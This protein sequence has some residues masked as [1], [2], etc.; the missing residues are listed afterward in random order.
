MQLNG[1]DDQLLVKNGVVMVNKVNKNG[2]ENMTPN[3]IQVPEGASD[4]DDGLTNTEEAKHEMWKLGVGA[5][6]QREQQ[7]T[8]P[9]SQVTENEICEWF[10]GSDQTCALVVRLRPM[11]V[12]EHDIQL[13]KDVAESAM[14]RCDVF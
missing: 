11:A 3:I 2:K 14:L 7:E 5:Q 1:D 10:S 8:I 12:R 6:C 4:N 9:L 13:R